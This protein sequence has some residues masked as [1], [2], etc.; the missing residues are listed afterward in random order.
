[1]SA[2]V[3]GVAIIMVRAPRVNAVGASGTGEQR[4]R[5]PDGARPPSMVGLGQIGVILYGIAKMSEAD[6]AWAATHRELVEAE[7]R[8]HEQS[9]TALRRLVRKTAPRGW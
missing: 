6:K 4:H 7:A 2:I 1:M 8:R 3:A 5:S 9:M